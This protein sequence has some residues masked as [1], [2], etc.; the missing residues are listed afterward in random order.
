MH[1]EKL[2]VIA[3]IDNLLL[4]VK[5]TA[6]LMPEEFTVT[7]KERHFIQYGSLVD[8]TYLFFTFQKIVV[9]GLKPILWAKTLEAL[10]SMDP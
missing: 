6:I 2:G 10:T 4:W 1:E 9:S 3:L 7:L 5:E 8:Y